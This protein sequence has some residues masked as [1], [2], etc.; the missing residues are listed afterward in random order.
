[1]LN[2]ISDWYYN[3]G[4]FLAL[5][6]FERVYLSKFLSLANKIAQGKV[7]KLLCNDFHKMHYFPVPDGQEKSHAEILYKESVKL[8]IRLNEQSCQLSKTL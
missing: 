7:R 2:F 5:D 3:D 1:L 8:A 4:S 6:D